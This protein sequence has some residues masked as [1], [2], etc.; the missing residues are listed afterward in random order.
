MRY[1]ICKKTEQTNQGMLKQ[2]FINLLTIDLNSGN[3]Y[4]ATGK[5][6]NLLVKNERRDA[7]CSGD[8]ENRC[9]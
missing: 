4:T 5:E 8:S 9:D 3:I 1:R 6:I 2:I 7:E